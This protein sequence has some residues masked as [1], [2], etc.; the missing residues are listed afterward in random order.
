MRHCMSN[1]KRLAGVHKH[2]KA[3][4]TGQA[5]RILHAFCLASPFCDRIM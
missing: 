4:V 2:L 5:I 3:S 1:P